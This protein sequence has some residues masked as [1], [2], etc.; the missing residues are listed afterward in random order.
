MIQR[1]LGSFSKQQGLEKLQIP[2][3]AKHAN[4]A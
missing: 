1:A 3:N 2:F 4:K